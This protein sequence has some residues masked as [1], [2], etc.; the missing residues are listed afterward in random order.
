MPGVELNIR[1]QLLLFNPAVRF[2]STDRAT[3]RVLTPFH[4]LSAHKV[5]LLVS[6]TDWDDSGFK[7]SLKLPVGY[8]R[9]GDKTQYNYWDQLAGHHLKSLKKKKKLF[10]DQPQNEVCFPLC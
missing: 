1:H 2:D 10:S 5:Q 6:I 8:V 4:K 3:R 9:D 7:N